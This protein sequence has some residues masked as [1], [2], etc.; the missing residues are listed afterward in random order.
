MLFV[1]G[2]QSL[3]RNKTQTAG[4]KQLKLNKPMAK[5]E[6]HSLT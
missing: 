6:F 2:Q 3:I 1:L 4:E 5:I